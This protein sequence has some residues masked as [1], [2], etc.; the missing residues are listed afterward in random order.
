MAFDEPD[1]GFDASIRAGGGD[2][3]SAKTRIDVDLSPV[4]LYSC[5][6][7]YDLLV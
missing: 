4:L 5:G 6:I 7:I 1:I 3:F 2:I